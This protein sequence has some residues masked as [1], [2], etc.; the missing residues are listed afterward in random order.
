MRK[1][2]RINPNITKRTKEANEDLGIHFSLLFTVDVIWL[3]AWCACLDFPQWW[4]LIW[5]NKLTKTFSPI[6]CICQAFF[7]PTEWNKDSP[8]AS[9]PG[10]FLEPVCHK[11]WFTFSSQIL[12]ILRSL[13]FSYFFHCLPSLHVLPTFTLY[14]FQWTV[15]NY[16]HLLGH[17]SSESPTFFSYL[18][19]EKRSLSL[20]TPLL[21]SVFF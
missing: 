16:S 18:E 19:Y 12:E 4:T 8:R 21:L 10:N 2:G 5:N 11:N 3:T 20:Y 15:L 6:N 17:H 7:P 1:N 14:P 13:L 9:L